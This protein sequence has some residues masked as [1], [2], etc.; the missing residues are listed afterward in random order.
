MATIQPVDLPD[1]KEWWLGVSSSLADAEASVARFFR[2]ALIGAAFIVA[3][4][5]AILV[6][7]STQII[8]GRLRLERV[9]REMLTSELNQAREIQL[10]WLPEQQKTQVPIDIAAVNRPASHVSGDFYNWF[11]LPDGRVCIVIGDVT[12][13]GLSAAFLMA[14]TQLLVRAIITR[15]PDPGQCL[16]E[17]NR[18]LCTH[19]FSGQ[20]VTLLV[21]I[22]DPRKNTKEF[23]SGW[24]IAGVS[25]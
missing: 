20:F 14:T 16:T 1:G 10:M 5:T 6:S 4:M 18:L 11:E 24:P 12:G 22:L 8:R 19:V 25:K 3:A 13:H 7:T 2:R 23:E 15:I 21:L 17:T 9:Q